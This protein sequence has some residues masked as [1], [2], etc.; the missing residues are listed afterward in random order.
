ME[1]L[2]CYGQREYRV[3]AD[4]CDRAAR[5]RFVGK[6]KM[7]YAVWFAALIP[8]LAW[9]KLRQRTCALL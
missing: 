6:M 7:K 9:A 5:V 4:G 3:L 1:R 2:V 8:F